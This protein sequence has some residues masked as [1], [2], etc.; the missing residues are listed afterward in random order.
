MGFHL[1]FGDP[2]SDLK[3]TGISGG[4]Y[5]IT[6]RYDKREYDLASTVFYLIR[7]K[8]TRSGM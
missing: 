6:L 3:T 7:K 4:S 1:R 8:E 5:G 2:M